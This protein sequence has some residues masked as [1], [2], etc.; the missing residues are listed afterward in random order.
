MKKVTLFL[1]LATTAIILSGCYVS[2]YSYQNRPYKAGYQCPPPIKVELVKE[3]KKEKKKHKHV[4][5]LACKP[6]CEPE[7]KPVHKPTCVY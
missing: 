2:P 3:K 4:C 5:E 6:T 7:C 1:S